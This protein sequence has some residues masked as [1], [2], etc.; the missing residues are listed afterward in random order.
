MECNT[1][2]KK[3]PWQLKSLLIFLRVIITSYPNLSPDPEIYPNLL[4][5]QDLPQLLT[6]QNQSPMCIDVESTAE[7]DGD[8]SHLAATC[9]PREKIKSRG[10]RE[11]GRGA[12]L[13]A[14]N[15]QLQLRRCFWRGQIAG[16][17][18]GW[19]REAR[20][21]AAC[22]VQKALSSLVF[23]ICELQS[24]GLQ[25]WS[26]ALVCD[27]SLRE[28]MFRVHREVHTSFC[29]LFGHIFA[30]TPTLMFFVMLLL[31]NFTVYSMSH[32]KSIKIM[33]KH[34]RITFSLLN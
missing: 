34:L 16:G 25:L 20:E 27:D 18:F 29:W 23:I 5:P 31:A 15:L 21:S 11:S 32:D 12:R 6:W 24:Y 14:E 17:G 19:I 1:H 7:A 30:S 33:Y 13:F 28:I 10:R 3:A 8:E 9:Q 22:S 26:G 4:K 2:E